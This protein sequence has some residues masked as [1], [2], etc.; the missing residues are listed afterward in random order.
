LAFTAK[1]AAKLLSAAE[2]DATPKKFQQV[3]GMNV[4]EMHRFMNHSLDIPRLPEPS[5]VEVAV[6]GLNAAEDEI[7]V[8]KACSGFHVVSLTT[9]HDSILGTCIGT[10]KL[11]LRAHKP[12]DTLDRLSLNLAVKGWRVDRS[13]RPVGKHNS[14]AEATNRSFLDNRLHLAERRFRENDFNHRALKLKNLQ[15][16]ADLFGSSKGT[17][18]WPKKWQGVKS[19]ENRRRH[20]N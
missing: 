1:S 10:A 6:S 5:I 2:E 13:P 17:D 4:A 14:F 19:T 7:S 9:N 3:Y 8:R 16:S 11:R 20:V 12:E 15:T 18:R